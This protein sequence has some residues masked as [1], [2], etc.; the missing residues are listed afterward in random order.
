M[1][2][3]TP[4][5]SNHSKLFNVPFPINLPFEKNP[6]N[7]YSPGE[8]TPLSFLRLNDKLIF[9]SSIKILFVD[10]NES[11]NSTLPILARGLSLSP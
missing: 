10:S 5:H 1:D 11:V 7:L 8:F 2:F 4:V 6:D 3:F 9:S